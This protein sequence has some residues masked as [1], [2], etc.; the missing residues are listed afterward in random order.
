MLVYY[1]SRECLFIHLLFALSAAPTGG[2]F[3][4]P[5]LNSKY[6]LFALQ[7]AG[8]VCERHNIGYVMSVQEREVCCF[9]EAGIQ[10]SSN[11]ITF[12]GV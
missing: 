1:N 9:T 2:M 5:G 4:L 8:A 6:Q 3:K 7:L 12:H 10:Q 11:G